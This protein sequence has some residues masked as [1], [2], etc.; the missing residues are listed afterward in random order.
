[1]TDVDN[2]LKDVAKQGRLKEFTVVCDESN[3]TPE[4]IDQ[5]RL[6]VDVIFYGSLAEH[7]RK[8]LEEST[9]RTASYGCHTTEDKV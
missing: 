7:V 8:R 6:N 4:D 9:D 5:R 1:M 2:F 3:N